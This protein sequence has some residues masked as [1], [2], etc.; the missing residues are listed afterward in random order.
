M[1]NFYRRIKI[2]Q[3]TKL[4]NKTILITGATGLI[5]SN[6][7]AFLNYINNRDNLNLKIIAIHHSK[8]EPWICFSPNIQYLRLNLTKEK[9]PENIKFNYLIHC[10]TYGQP[11]KFISFP[12]E[13]VRLNINLLFDLL[14]LNKKN[15]ATFLYLSSSEIYGEVNKENVPTPESFYGYV[16]TLSDR[17]IYSES[18]RL[19]ETICHS[20]H[21]TSSIKIARL[22]ISYG[23]GVKYDDQ[24]VIPEFIKK[25]LVKKQVEIMDNGS[26][27]RSFCF[28]SDTIEMLLN[29]MISGKEFV[30]NVGGNTI[31]TITDL[32]QIVAS[33][34][35]VKVV[36]SL[37]NE[38]IIGA[39]TRT[40][41]DNHRYQNEFGNKQFVD[42]KEGLTSTSVWLSKLIPS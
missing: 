22:L 40:I 15:K 39:P 13:T 20:Y 34:N 5:G 37:K 7:V 27:E 26:A 1:I 2:N 19:A 3:K 25:A 17:A 24:R 32:A 11:K 18:K 12:Q 42:L 21:K 28:I 31:T 35:K 36:P 41:L 4:K 29:I 33:I 30:Y 6:L 9:L 16:D 23:P 38:N 8:L 14:E 10:A